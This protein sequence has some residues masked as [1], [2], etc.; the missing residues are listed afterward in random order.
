MPLSLFRRPGNVQTASP[1][2]D[3]NVIDSRRVKLVLGAF[4]L[5]SGA[6][7]SAHAQDNVQRE[8]GR[9][10]ITNVPA[11]GGGGNGYV[12][13]LQTLLNCAG[14]P[15]SYERLMGLSGM[16]FIFQVDT[17]HRWE[18]KVDAGWWPLDPWGL[19]LHREFLSRAVGYEL[20]GAGPFF[21]SHRW[22][23]SA[24]ECRDTYLKQMHPD[25]VR[26]IDA[27]RPALTPF[28]PSKADFGYVITGYDRDMTA[29]RPPIWG[30]SATDTKGS[31]GYCAD[32]PFGVIMLGRQLTPMDVDEA[33]LMALRQAIALA[34][35]QA[36]PAEAPWR[37]RRFT[38]GKAWVA[39]AALLRNEAEP[40]ESRHHGNVRGNLINN[41]T[42]AV[43][44]LQSVAERRG[45]RAAEELRG[46]A[47]AYA[48]VLKQVRLLDAKDLSG[49]AEKRRRLADHVDLIAKLEQEAVAHLEQAVDAM[50]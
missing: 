5:I 9:V 11:A 40:T 20:K 7:L 34:R 39:W 25:V 43:A 2:R 45:G 32:W 35:D 49:N 17:E 12:R 14:A 26:Q 44:Y 37:D 21:D 28:S 36:G 15:V 30:R 48:K 13:G 41:R 16:A 23:M 33:D 4:L 3:L 18:G 22:P 19:K 50:K 24:N 8:E 1:K 46:A 38:G 42:A 6:I 47:N 29:D 27:G 31:Y 10:R